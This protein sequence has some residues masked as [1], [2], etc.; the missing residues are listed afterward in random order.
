MKFMAVST[1]SKLVNRIPEFEGSQREALVGRA[2]EGDAG[3]ICELTWILE[4]G[5]FVERDLGLALELFQWLKKNERPTY[6][7]EC[8]RIRHLI[9]PSLPF[10]QAEV[11]KP[12]LS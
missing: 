12:W 8:I 3:A 2:L 5:H 4:Q 6:E 10:K 9:D 7:A 1:I 11:R